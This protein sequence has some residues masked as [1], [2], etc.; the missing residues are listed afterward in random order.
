MKINPLIFRN[1]DIRG[2]VPEDLDYE[3]VLAIA[4]AYGT[5]LHK[6][7]IR[8]AVVGYDCRLSGT[9]FRDAYI[10]GLS[11]CGIDVIDIGMVMT[12]MMYYAQYR[13]Q[14]NGGTMITASHNPWNFNGFKM[15]TGFSQ[16]TMK[17]DVQEIKALAES[18]DFYEAAECGRLEK[19]DVRED[20]IK[21]ILKRVR[22]NKKFKVVVDSRHGTTGIYAPEILERVGCEV[23]ARNIEVD[24]HFPKGTPDPTDEKFM[25]Q[26]GELVVKEGADFGVAF[27]GDGDRIGVVDEK[28]RI[29]WNDVLVAIFAQE[30]LSR[31][32]GSKI[33]HNTLCS[34]LVT[35]VI[36]NS[37]GK[38]IMWLTGHAFIKDKIASEGAAFGGELSGHFF[39]KD[40]A[41]GHDDGTYAILRVLE[42]LSEKGISLSELFDSFPVYISSPEV[43]IGCPDDKKIAVIHNLSKR[44]K[45]D[46]P[47]GQVTDE[48]VIPGDDGVRVDFPDGMMI[49][50]YSQ[51]GPYITVRFEAREQ[52]VYEMRKKYT[53]DIL[54]SYPEM[55]WEDELC[56][57]LESLD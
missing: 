12:Q 43:K 38:P 50:R 48:N 14:A 19:A 39:F 40:N 7:K 13:F 51:N 37:G 55:I 31:F 47:E 18:E 21:D 35:E 57:N 45:A 33:I 30:I 41:Y 3:K 34:G 24:G 49:F 44:F 42:Y 10:K 8:Q 56:V 11:F 27:D 25:R 23:V 46:F 52:S 36:K 15:A 28:G 1:Y 29:L 54:K 32:P 17:E 6:R 16:T 9:E 22:I 5:F 2:K 20:Y 26:L 53:K 4:K